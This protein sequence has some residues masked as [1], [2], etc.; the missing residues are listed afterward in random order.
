MGIFFIIFF[1]TVL[2]YIFFSLYLSFINIDKYVENLQMLRRFFYAIFVVGISIGLML[3]KINLD[4]WK[5]LLE[6]TA[7]FVFIDLAVFQTP[8]ILKIWNAEFKHDNYI[9][10]IIKK[11]EEIISYNS[12]KVECFTDIVL[13]KSTNY[14][15]NIPLH[16]K[17]DDYKE[18]LKKFLEFYTG[19]FQID[20]AIFEFESGLNANLE[21]LHSNLDIKQAF[22]RIEQCYNKTIVDGEW[23]LFLVQELLD[24]KAIELHNKK[25]VS[26]SDNFK[27]KKVFIIPFY[28]RKYDIL[29]G[30][31]STFIEV[32]GI[33]ASHILNLTQIFDWYMD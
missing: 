28:G 25:E 1:L 20:L 5:Q 18:D 13:N 14:L 24:G 19:T 12:Q 31:S 27:D 33:D 16:L 2:V 29:I 6:L 11:N 8:D 26:S 22:T 30:I 10:K 9:R 3:E 32:D 15:N 4:D 7:L 17:F 23:K 21:D